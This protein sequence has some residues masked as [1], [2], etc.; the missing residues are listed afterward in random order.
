MERACSIFSDNLSGQAT[1]A[2]F[3]A[4]P[5]GAPCCP[6]PR[7]GNYSDMKA[8]EDGSIEKNIVEKALL[9]FSRQPSL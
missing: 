1:G 8:R 6:H 9:H 2:T 4:L 3:P 5:S 7:R